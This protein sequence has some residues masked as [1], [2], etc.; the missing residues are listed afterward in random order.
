MIALSF[1]TISDVIQGC[2]IDSTEADNAEGT[3]PTK[4]TFDLSPLK[5]LFNGVD[6]LAVP[7]QGVPA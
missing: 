1:V 6:D 7:L 5:I 4:R 2:T 3:D